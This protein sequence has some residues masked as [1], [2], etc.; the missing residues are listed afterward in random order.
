M[1]AGL[2]YREGLVIGAGLAT[3]GVI[4]IGA[5]T[6]W[7]S[8]PATAETGSFL[9]H[10]EA[11]FVFTSLAYALGPDAGESNACPNGLSQNVTEIFGQSPEGRRPGEGDGEYSKRLDAGGQRISVA[12]DGRSLSDV[13]IT[14]SPA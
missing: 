5:W 11:G 8:G 13:N 10:G 12:S 9:R 6:L 3:A 7:S 1:G 4:G 2:R 14:R